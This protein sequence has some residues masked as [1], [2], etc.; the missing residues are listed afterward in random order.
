MKTVEIQEITY[1]GESIVG[2][3]NNTKKGPELQKSTRNSGKS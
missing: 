2:I 3:G 1:E